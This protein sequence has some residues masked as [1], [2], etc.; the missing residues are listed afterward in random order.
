MRIMQRRSYIGGMLLMICIPRIQLEFGQAE[1]K[2][3][4]TGV[5]GG[6]EDC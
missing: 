2:W 4:E 3:D 5:H 6:P 1:E